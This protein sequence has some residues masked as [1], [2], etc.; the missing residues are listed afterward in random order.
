MKRQL[1]SACLLVLLLAFALW[2][3]ASIEGEPVAQM[4]ETE[5]WE[6]PYALLHQAE[7]RWAY[8]DRLEIEA[9]SFKA[10]FLDVPDGVS[11]EM[12]FL[13][14]ALSSRY[15]WSVAG[16]SLNAFA[17]G[18]VDFHNPTTNGEVVVIAGGST[19]LSDAE[20]AAL[21][22]Y[23]DNGGDLVIFAGTNLNDFACY[24]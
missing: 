19:P 4:N 7:T 23:V 13:K 21:Q 20:L 10:Y 12:G 14:E 16:I 1:L 11:T 18:D 17:R 2:S 22:D 15:R 5:R 8:L 3:S 6:T 24:G 9:G